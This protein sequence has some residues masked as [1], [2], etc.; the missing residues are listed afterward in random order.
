[1]SKK[2]AMKTGF[3]CLSELI[4]M[5]LTTKF[6]GHSHRLVGSCTCVLGKHNKVH[7]FVNA[8]MLYP[9]CHYDY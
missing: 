9:V 8:I 1:M 5:L 3:G 6:P 4:L 2:E 7:E